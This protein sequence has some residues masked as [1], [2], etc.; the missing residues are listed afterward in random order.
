MLV[1][2]SRADDEDQILA[3]MR[4]LAWHAVPE[5][6]GLFFPGAAL[7]RLSADLA[8]G[9]AGILLALHTVVEAKDDLLSLLPT[10]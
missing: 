9:A 2:L 7:H 5:E 1:R 10:G 6:Q 3:S 4:R 8:T